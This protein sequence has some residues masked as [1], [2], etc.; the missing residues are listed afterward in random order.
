MRSRR[1]K[2][3]HEICGRPSLEWVLAACR[4]AGCEELHVVVGAGADEVKASF[5]GSD[6]HWVT[7]T[8]QRGTGHAVQTAFDAISATSRAPNA[9]DPSTIALIVYADNP[10]MT[11]AGLRRL[12][13]AAEVGWASLAVATLDQPGA[14]GR[15]LR[16]EDGQLNA[17]IEFADADP[18]QRLIQQVNAGQYAVPFETFAPYLNTLE[19][20]N[21]QGE[22]YLTDAFV[23]A[24]RDGRRVHCVDLDDPAEAWGINDR[25]DL[26]NAHAEFRRRIVADL[27]ASGVTVLDPDRITV[28]PEVRV[29]E[30]V[31]LHP[32]VWLGG[33]THIASGCVLHQ[34]AWIRDSRLAHEVEILPYSVLD[35]AAV[36]ERCTVGPFARLRPGTELE[37][38]VR[39][40]NFVEVKKAHFGA[41]AKASHLAYIGDASVGKGANLGAGV[42]TCNYDGKNKHR[43]QI[44]DGAFVGSD[45]MLVAPV[46]VG[47]GSI[48][49]AGS[50][51]TEDV[52][53]HSLAL[54]RA[55]QRNLKGWVKRKNGAVEEA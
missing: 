45:T 51:I 28:G 37:S 2:V 35:G 29:E 5:S 50:V 23:K 49:G 18:E 26:A 13:D 8:E 4:E 20:G 39:I 53:D 33:K 6:L 16:D 42:V 43:T 55:R 21:A 9:V 1:P 27:M 31:V 52:P 19:T 54:G 11:A 38:D 10:L 32:D 34:G 22:L 46:S 30:D 3:L 40:G 36:G 7:Q 25:H 48:T 41:G 24:A 44:G 14:L 12:A 17:L 47:A 15:V